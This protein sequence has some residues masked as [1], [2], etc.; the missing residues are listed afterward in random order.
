MPGPALGIKGVNRVT[1]KTKIIAV[2]KLLA[3]QRHTTTRTVNKD[4]C[5]IRRREQTGFKRTGE[6]TGGWTLARA[7]MEVC[8]SSS[9]A[10]FRELGLHTHL[11]PAG[12][13]LQPPVGG[14]GGE[15][16]SRTEFTF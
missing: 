15:G 11:H 14:G 1:R 3:S 16:G 13:G 5:V 6:G 4:C 8:G 10:C 9:H 7:V 2:T 12:N